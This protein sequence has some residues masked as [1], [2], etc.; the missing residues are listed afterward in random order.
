MPAANLG[1]PSA[2]DTG[3][4]PRAHGANGCKLRLCLGTTKPLESALHKKELRLLGHLA[5]VGTKIRPLRRGLSVATFRN[6]RKVGGE[7]PRA[8]LIQMAKGTV[9]RASRGAPGAKRN[10]ACERKV[11]TG[12]GAMW[13]MSTRQ[14]IL[15]TFLIVV[16]RLQGPSR[17]GQ[18]LRVPFT[19]KGQTNVR[20]EYAE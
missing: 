20:V 6:C 3:S 19:S 16:P 12:G 18:F 5:G 2:A 4:A 17:R 10:I 11:P 7:V 8:P 15:H 9:W 14:A 13:L 1:W